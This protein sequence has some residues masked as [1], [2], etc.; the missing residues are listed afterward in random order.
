MRSLLASCGAQINWYYAITEFPPPP[1][2]AVSATAIIWK[3][4]LNFFVMVYPFVL[5]LVSEDGENVKRLHP[6]T[7]SDMEELQV[8]VIFFLFLILCLIIAMLL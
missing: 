4:S 6:L 2:Y 5:Q 7:E 3:E 1:V 8:G